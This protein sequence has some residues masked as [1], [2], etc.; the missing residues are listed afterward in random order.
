M[1]APASLRA[2]W[3]LF[4]AI[5]AGLLAIQWALYPDPPSA[6][7]PRPP[8]PSYELSNFKIQY[9]Y[10]DPRDEY[11]ER[12][13]DRSGQAA[14][15]YD[16]EWAGDG[17]P[18]TAECVIVLYGKKGQK[19]GRVEFS[20]KSYSRRAPGGNAFWPQIAVSGRPVSAGGSCAD[21][22]YPAEGV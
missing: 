9:P 8:G 17:F 15:S 3:L 18:G 16:S 2:R 19:V 1:E 13:V 10:V 5:S 7:A 11:A 12:P 4:L 21:S 14:V 20:L 22:V 6:S